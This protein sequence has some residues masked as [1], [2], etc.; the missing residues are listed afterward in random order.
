MT[1]LLNKPVAEI[2]VDDL[3]ILIDQKVSENEQLEYKSTLPSKRGQDIWTID[4]SDIG[5][6]AKSSILEEVV[7]FANAQGGVLLVGI[8]ESQ[9]DKNFPKSL[10]GLR[11]CEN[12]VDRFKGIFRDCVEP[13]IPSLEIKAIQT[14][15]DEGVLMIRVGKSR[16][17]PHRVTLTKNCTI[18]RQDRCEEL[19]MTEIQDLTLNTTRGLKRTN[20]DLKDRKKRFEEEFNRLTTPEQAIGLR[21]TGVPVDLRRDIDQLFVNRTI[22]S[23]FSLPIFEIKQADRL[24]AEHQYLIEILSGSV[25]PILRGA[26]QDTFRIVTGLLDFAFGEVHCNGLIELGFLSVAELFENHRLNPEIIIGLFAHLL[27][28]V[29]KVRDNTT[30]TRSEYLIDVEFRVRETTVCLGYD[31][32]HMHVR[33]EEIQLTDTSFPPYPFGIGSE[34]ELLLNQFRRDLFHWVGWDVGDHDVQFSFKKL[35]DQ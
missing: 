6:Y 18:R 15:D 28:W 8:E 2:S 23:R 1:N 24:L 16:A 26:R 3:D 14:K 20:K 35:R 4:Q 10:Q 9:N 30:S 7:A 32:G 27:K 21:I 29:E 5:K 31:R 33:N 22:D 34:I 12:L 13:V 11:K 19:S 25:R 17:A